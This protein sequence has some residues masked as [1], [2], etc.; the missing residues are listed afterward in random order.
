[1]RQLIRQGGKSQEIRE[2]A[3]NL[4]MHHDTDQGKIGAIFDF[5]KAKMKYVRD[6]LNQELVAGAPYHYN[7]LASLGYARGDCDDHTVMLGAMLESVGYPTRIAT[8]R[9]KP[10]GGSYDHVY[11]EV[12][13]RTGWIPLDASNK[14]RSAGDVPPSNRLRRW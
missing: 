2:M 7:T 10:G 12:H 1:M 5:V 3:A 9:M 8:A 14:K 4:A 13:D 11:L 6:P